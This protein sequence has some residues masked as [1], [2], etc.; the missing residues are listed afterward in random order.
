VHIRLR[1][2][3]ASDIAF[4][5]TLYCETMRWIIERLF[6]WHE[7]REH[8]NFNQFFK[9]DEVRIITADGQDVG[10]IQQQVEHTSINL[11]SFYV[12]PAMQRQGV[13]TQVLQLL[14]TNARNQAKTITLAVVKIN[15]AVQ[16]YAKHGF[17]IT[18][19]DEHKFYMRSEP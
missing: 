2:A 10:W 19:E 13:G 14:L 12:A 7:V 1:E 8:A 3:Y 6:G 15:P 5:R 9:L 4:A 11:G 18:R 16:F 17:R